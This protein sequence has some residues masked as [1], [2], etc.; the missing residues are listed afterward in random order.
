[1]YTPPLPSKSSDVVARGALD[2][3]FVPS[4][5]RFEPMITGKVLLVGVVLAALMSGIGFVLLVLR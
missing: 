3:P 5:P 1:M 4:A 2:Q